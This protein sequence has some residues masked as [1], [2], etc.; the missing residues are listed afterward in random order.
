MK[1]VIQVVGAR[2]NFIKVAPI[3]RAFK[4]LNNWN[5]IIVHTGQHS[6]KNMSEVFFEQ[7]E[8]F[9]M[10]WNKIWE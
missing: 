8:Y 1:K 5:S 7:L 10:H 4:L 3:H 2:P 9:G 6:D